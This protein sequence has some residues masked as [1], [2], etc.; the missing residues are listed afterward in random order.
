MDIM[1]FFWKTFFFTGFFELTKLT[2]KVEE[3][4]TCLNL[5]VVN[6]PSSNEDLRLPE[7]LTAIVHSIR[8]YDTCVLGSS[9]DYFRLL[10]DGF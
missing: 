2:L 6:L 9:C 10:L 4:V 8:S 7:V 1:K 3:G 5:A